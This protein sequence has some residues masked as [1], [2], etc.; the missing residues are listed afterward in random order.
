MNGDIVVCGAAWLVIV[1]SHLLADLEPTVQVSAV[2]TLTIG[3][4]MC[5]SDAVNYAQAP[6]RRI[7]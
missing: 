5:C 6:K 4:L 7:A 2:G 1:D 3:V